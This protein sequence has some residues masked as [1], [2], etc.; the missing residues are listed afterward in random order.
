MPHR[1]IRAP[2]AI[3]LPSHIAER[4][5]PPVQMGARAK[6]RIHWQLVDRQG[7]VAREGETHNMIL[8]QGLDYVPTYGFATG[9][10]AY[11]AVGTNSTAPT[12]SD[13]ALGAEVARTNATFASTSLTRTADGVYDLVKNFEFGYAEA[14]GNLTEFGISPLATTPGY[15][16]SRE[17]FRS[18]TGTAETVTKT[19]AYKLHIV[20]TLTVTLGPTVSTVGS[21]AITNV[22]PNP[23]T[24]HYMLVAPNQ[25]SRKSDLGLI[26]WLILR[27]T[28]ARKGTYGDDGPAID[29]LTVDSNAYLDYANAHWSNM[30]S[31]GMVAQGSP[32]AYVAGSHQIGSYQQWA[33]TAYMNDT[34]YGFRM[35]GYSSYYTG[36]TSDPGYVFAF[37]AGTSFTKDNLHSLSVG[38]PIVSWSR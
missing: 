17:L 33:D 27:T 5:P 38:T 24:G 25:S 30:V 18:G 11:C 28:P 4:R 23:L 10:I 34:I 6:G 26:N 32:P 16:F 20:Y 13:T 19:S 14:N 9:M 12:V 1:I 31:H 21:V 29:S 2:N 15:L 7:R 36:T 37:D 8:D 22:T 35:N 3:V